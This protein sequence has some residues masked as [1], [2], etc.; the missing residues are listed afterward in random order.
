MAANLKQSKC[1]S[2]SVTVPMAYRFYRMLLIIERENQGSG[3][4]GELQK[5]TRVPCTE[6]TVLY[7]DY[8]NYTTA[9]NY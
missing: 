4:G 3:K 8:C 6:G 5:G 7:L 9:Y 1:D 2:K